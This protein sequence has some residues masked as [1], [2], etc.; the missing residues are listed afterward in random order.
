MTSLL[1]LTSKNLEVSQLFLVDLSELLRLYDINSALAQLALGHE[2]ARFTE[3]FTRFM[4]KQARILSGLPEPN[5]E[6]L[7]CPLIG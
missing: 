4:L 1:R 7:V 6:L 3:K 5:A 2:C